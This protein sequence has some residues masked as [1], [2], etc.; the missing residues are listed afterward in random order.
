V[1]LNTITL[2][3]RSNTNVIIRD[4][5]TLTRDL[6]R[7]LNKTNTLLEIS[8]FIDDNGMAL[9]VR[10]R[11][12]MVSM[13]FNA[14]VNTISAISWRW[15]QGWSSFL[16]YDPVWKP[17]KKASLKPQN[18]LKI[19]PDRKFPLQSSLFMLVRNER[20]MQNFKSLSQV[21]ENV[22]HAQYWKMQTYL[23]TLHTVSEWLLFSTNPAMF[24]LYHGENKFIFNP[25][26]MRSALY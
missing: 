23:P 14:T 19:Y 20:R 12:R 2:T 25:M 8:L 26:I 7:K 21:L 18:Y 1:A 4:M 24:Q 6:V 15:N 3:G 22:Q 9:W 11:G 5:C 13:V 16:T 10:N 17:L